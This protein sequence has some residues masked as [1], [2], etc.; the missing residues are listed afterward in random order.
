MPEFRVA[1]RGDSKLL[2]EMERKYIECPWSEE[3]ILGTISDES[4]AIYI[5]QS[6]DT[7]IGYGGVKTVL[8]TAE[9]YNIA[10]EKEHRR[11]GYGAAILDKLIEHA[12][13]RGAAEMF[14]EVNENNAPA[15]ALYTSR[16]FEISHIRKNYYKSGNA[17]VLKKRV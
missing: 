7:A 4:S 17:L 11:K 6:G 13:S 12:V 2:A 14:L 16:G 10:V 5:L 9:I 8:D 1:T 3:V 15:I